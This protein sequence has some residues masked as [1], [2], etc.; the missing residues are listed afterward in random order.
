MALVDGMASLSS[1][2]QP[3]FKFNLSSSQPG[4]PIHYFNEL[5]LCLNDILRAWKSN[6]RILDE[7]DKHSVSN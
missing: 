5:V 3:M 4:R 7:N 1:A 2:M 6:D